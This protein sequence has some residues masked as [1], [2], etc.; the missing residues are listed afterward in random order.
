[1]TARMRKIALA[2]HIATSVGWAG[3]VS[4]FLALAVSGLV[5]PS[6]PTVRAAYVG[7]ELTTWYVI[8]PL[9]VASFFTGVI[10]SLGTTW[11]LFRHYWV[12]LKLLITVLATAVLILHLEPI[13]RLAATSRDTGMPGPDLHQA[14]MLM[15]YASGA[16]V[17]ALLIMTALSIYKPRGM[18]PYGWRR[19]EEARG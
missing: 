9:A 4:A 10:S 18:T 8:V 19:Q 17:L 7:M 14:R 5:S 1:M 15:I 16:A 6:A 2:A 3:A 12:L 13:G 11:G